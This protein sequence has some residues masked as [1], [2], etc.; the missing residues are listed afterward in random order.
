MASVAIEAPGLGGQGSPKGNDG[1]RSS[2]QC[3]SGIFVIL[4]Q[5]LDV[6]GL[7]KEGGQPPTR[8]YR[9]GS[10]SPSRHLRL[11]RQEIIHY[12]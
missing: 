1:Q 9:A 12:R 5:S 6:I 11:D 4:M 7:G 2:L 3:R 8:L 10:S